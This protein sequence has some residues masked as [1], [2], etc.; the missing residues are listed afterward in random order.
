MLEFFTS[1]DMIGS[2]QCTQ[3]FANPLFGCN[4]KRI[5]FYLSDLLT[6]E[7]LSLMTRHSTLLEQIS[8]V[9]CRRVTDQGIMAITKNQA[10]LRKI[11]LRNIRNLTS[12]GLKFI[13][14]RF[15]H[16][17]DISG[18]SK[19]TSEGVFFLVFNNPA[20][21][22]LYLNNCRSLD[23]QCLY[24]IAHGVGKNLMTLQLDFLPN[25]LDP[26]TAIF[27][28]SQQCPN[29]AQL[30]LCRFFEPD[31]EADGNRPEFRI[32]GLG[33]RDVDLYG[34]YFTTLPALPPTLHT[35]SLSVTGREDVLD[36][37][38][39]LSR[40][41]LLR[42]I[43]LQLDCD[44]ADISSV[45]A[46]NRFLCIFIPYMSKKI[47][48]LHVAIPRLSEPALAHITECIPNLRHLAVDGAHLS[49]YYI[50]K[51][52]AGGSRSAGSKLKSLRLCDVGLTYRA[53]FAIARGGCSLTELEL[54]K[55]SCVDDRF[56]A[57]LAENCKMLQSVNFNKC[58]WVS[59][60]GL[61]ALVR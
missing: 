44:D 6:D 36:L 47:T 38:Q 53:L 32:E 49:S 40:Q 60:R 57:V 51:Y 61:S 15:L 1:H 41:P 7:I 35:I 24:D 11:E 9:E 28:L 46:A 37:V 17:V 34:N 58:K 29:I 4:L 25:V 16:T 43:H 54:S 50:R 27:N 8:L 13:K 48:R 2:E 56:L 55:M 3:L 10:K 23:D 33:L 22:N 59:D 19:V 52:F 20:I 5:S 30:S 21:H 31:F 26:A 45:E 14:S 42:S 18:C 39:R 12:D